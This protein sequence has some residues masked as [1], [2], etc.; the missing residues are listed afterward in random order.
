MRLR[1]WDWEK[2]YQIYLKGRTHKWPPYTLN[3][4]T[5]L[6]RKYNRCI[7]TVMYKER[8]T[9]GSQPLTKREFERIDYLYEQGYK[10]PHHLNKVS[11]IGVYRI[12]KYYFYNLV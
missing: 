5:Y 4:F 2:L 10:T 6:Y 11:K 9:K 1:K 3:R 8:L 7:N 12:K